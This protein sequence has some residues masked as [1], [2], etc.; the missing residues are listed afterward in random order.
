MVLSD[1]LCT[2]FPRVARKNRTPTEIKERAPEP[3]CPLG[4]GLPKAKNRRL[5]KSCQ[6]IMFR[7]GSA[8]QQ[9]A[10]DLVVEP[11]D[12]R[13]LKCQQRIQVD[14][15][16]GKGCVRSHAHLIVAGLNQRFG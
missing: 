10:Q 11:I 14:R 16:V 13:I 7:F 9:Y 8:L 15:Y 12:R 4:E 1:L 2:V 6:L 3:E 5:R